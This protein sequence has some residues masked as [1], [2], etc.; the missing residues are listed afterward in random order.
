MI[1]IKKRV[2]I[3]LKRINYYRK[4]V[5]FFG[6]SLF[7]FIGFIQ[8]INY[9]RNT[10][11][12]HNSLLSSSSKINLKTN[13][14]DNKEL[15]LQKKQFK[16]QLRAE[17]EEQ[18]KKIK[19]NRN[20]LCL[21]KS[22]NNELALGVIVDKEEDDL[23]KKYWVLAP[24]NT[25]PFPKENTA[26]LNVT[27]QFM[28]KIDN[29]KGQWIKEDALPEKLE[30][31]R[32]NFDILFFKT[33]KDYEIN[34]IR[35]NEYYQGQRL[36][37]F[38][39]NPYALVVFQESY[40]SENYL[41]K[42]DENTPIP[43]F[44]RNHSLNKQTVFFTEEG[45]LVGFLAPAQNKNEKG[46]KYLKVIPP[47]DLNN[48]L[49]ERKNQQKIALNTPHKQEGSKTNSKDFQLLIENLNK[50][51][52]CINTGSSL[53]TG[54]IVKKED[55]KYEGN[56]YYVLTNRH[57]IE[58]FWN[59]KIKNPYDRHLIALTN[60][61]IKG[62]KDVPAELFAVIGNN[63]EYDDIAILTFKTR[64]AIKDIDEN[65]EKYID[66]EEDSKI[67]ITQG[68][69]VYALGCQKGF[70][71]K[72][73]HLSFFEWFFELQP[74]EREG[75]YKQ[76]LFKQG[77]ISYFNEREINS[78]MTLDPGNSG[79]PLFN[80]QGQLI[81]INKS[82]YKN[83]RISQSINI[84]HVK[85]QFYTILEAKKKKNVPIFDLQEENNKMTKDKIEELTKG[86]FKKEIN[87]QIPLEDFY[88]FIEN[89]KDKKITF[90][91]SD[92]NDFDDFLTIQLH[93]LES[94]QFV[95]SPLSKN[96]IVEISLGLKE[97]IYF[98]RSKIYSYTNKS[99]PI[100]EET[101]RIKREDAN[102]LFLV[103]NIKHLSKENLLQ[104]QKDE[105][106]QKQ[107][108]IKNKDITFIKKEILQALV[109]CQN[110]HNNSLG[111]I[112]KKEVLNDRNNN[113]L[114][115]VVC[116]K[117]NFFNLFSPETK[118]TLQ[119]PYGLQD[120]E[121]KCICINNLNYITFISDNNYPVVETN[122][123]EK[124]LLLGEALYLI[125]DCND[126]SDKA[127]APHIFQSHLA[128]EIN[129]A[130]PQIMVDTTFLKEFFIIE[131]NE[132]Y[133]N[134]F[135]FNSQGNLINVCDKKDI[136]KI[137][138]QNFPFI[139]FPKMNLTS[140]WFCHV[141][142]IK[143]CIFIFWTFL[144]VVVFAIMDYQNEKKGKYYL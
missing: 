44:G 31:F 123:N 133:N 121:G 20:K 132:H 61:K 32:D 21:L 141:N 28:D 117:N 54:I 106:S 72:I 76:N 47:L 42:Q 1:N 8:L 41:L 139:V 82:F 127:L 11:T 24:K 98:L 116:K 124:D 136:A 125:S 53:G 56:K 93:G 75:K 86:V 25:T 95:A 126:V 59:K 137:D 3:K 143:V 60:P 66:F 135:I 68:E 26:V 101:I 63:R 27:I 84:N 109:L 90:K 69:I 19:N 118:I 33:K 16:V 48:Q 5:L 111:V 130:N 77:I 10:C 71:E 122:F 7:L 74:P 39:L 17:E 43:V 50:I 92:K 119:T 142:F 2:T 36:Q 87:H 110:N 131:D 49:E 52:V 128:V 112:I 99:S 15:E 73:Q 78:D 4:F 29:E 104:K 80:S 83:I 6:I 12:H 97:N 115:T 96:N 114:Y 103:F 23:L 129:P 37:T 81:G 89:S 46:V 79:G 35:K 51:T 100:Y 64:N 88:F 138:K 105:L 65:I 13:P 57:V 108:L 18:A 40:V 58:S 45:D 30:K 34:P 140:K 62:F 113:F 91:S 67:N 38:V 107:T 55:N 144:C 85:K 70:Q 22:S 120:E 94:L 134:W 14:S 102:K 9:P